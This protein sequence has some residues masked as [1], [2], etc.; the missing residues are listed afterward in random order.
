MKTSIPTIEKAIA[1]RAN[2]TEENINIRLFWAYKHSLEAGN[3]LINFYDVIWEH[4]IESIVDNLNYYK[5]NEFSISSNFSGLITIL[6]A[7]DKYGFTIVWKVVNG[8]PDTLF[9]YSVYT[10]TKFDGIKSG[11]KPVLFGNFDFYCIAERGNRIIRRLS[12]RYAEHGQV[13]FIGTQR[14]DAKLVDPE[15]VKTLEI[16]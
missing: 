2:S 6:A 7:F 1:E 16:K 5:I 8:E 13:G 15:A 9:G 3:D 4:D 12:E 10:T 14:V 11:N